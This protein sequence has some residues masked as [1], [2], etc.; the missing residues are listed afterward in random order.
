[1]PRAGKSRCWR[2]QIARE[3]IYQGEDALGRLTVDNLSQQR[4]L[5]VRAALDFA[6]SIIAKRRRLGTY[7]GGSDAL[8]IEKLILTVTRTTRDMLAEET[9]LLSLRI[10]LTICS[11]LLLPSYQSVSF[12]LVQDLPGTPRSRY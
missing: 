12:P 3:S 1:L 4:R 6:Q 8:E 7:P 10:E 9:R 11:P 2:Y 5:E